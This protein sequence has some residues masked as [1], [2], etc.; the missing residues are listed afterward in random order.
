MALVL[1]PTVGIPPDDTTTSAACED[2]V[3][4]ACCAVWQH[5]REIGKRRAGRGVPVDLKAAREAA[6]SALE[7]EHQCCV[8][9]S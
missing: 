8:V 6:M 2:V 1:G 9:L 7:G 3:D 5:Q 4:R